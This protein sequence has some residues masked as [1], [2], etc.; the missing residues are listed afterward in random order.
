[1]GHQDRHRHVCQNVAGGAS[2]HDLAEARMAVATHD[3]KV[4]LGSLAAGEERVTDV[5]MPGFGRFCTA[6]YIIKRQRR[7]NV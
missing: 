1:M 4:G 7:A 3:Q 6:R 2:K 5:P